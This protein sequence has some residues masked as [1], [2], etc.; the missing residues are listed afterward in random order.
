[1]LR[2]MCKG[3]IHRARI[4]E[5]NL[6][7]VGSL[8]IDVDLLERSDILPY[9][10]IHVVNVTNGQRLVTYAIEGERGSGVM[11]LNGAA[12]HRGEV[13]DVI[14]VIA[15]GHCNDDEARQL[16][17]RVVFVDENNRPHPLEEVSM[18]QIE[19]AIVEG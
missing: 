7:Y 19:A 16:Q 2:V 8:T 6:D 10:Q 11:C 18:A 12:A 1:M 3:K 9:E 4:T 15:Y 13:G 17:P 5:A 14:I